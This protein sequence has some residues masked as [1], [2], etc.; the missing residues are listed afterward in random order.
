M[1]WLLAMGGMRAEA[2]K[3]P[4]FVMVTSR[5]AFEEDIRER[6]RTRGW[7]SLWQSTSSHVSNG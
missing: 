3:A 2:I 5:G 7:S 1:T 6:R 4:S